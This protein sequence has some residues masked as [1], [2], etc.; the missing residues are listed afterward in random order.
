M[1]VS[2][3]NEIP[4]ISSDKKV[5]KISLFEIL[6]SIGNIL[7]KIAHK[8]MQRGSRMEELFLV[9]VVSRAQKRILKM[10]LV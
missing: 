3:V 5:T 8:G 1:Y 7:K 4:G 9:P 10:T 6:Y 2:F